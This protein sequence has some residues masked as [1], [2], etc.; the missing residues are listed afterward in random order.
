[1]RLTCF[2]G[3]SFGAINLL[4]CCIR[5]NYFQSKVDAVEILQ[6]LCSF[7]LTKDFIYGLNEL[8]TYFAELF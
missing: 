6:R 8:V 7:E 2:N 3:F 1:M 4:A 5:L